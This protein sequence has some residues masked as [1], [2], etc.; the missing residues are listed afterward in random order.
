MVSAGA[1]GVA[2]CFAIMV[3]SN[4]ISQVNGFGGK[5]NKTL[6]DEYPTYLSPD[7][8][9]FAIWGFIY[10]F[11]IVLVGAQ[12]CP[13][14]TTER[15]LSRTC[16]LTGLDVRGRLMAAF[17]ANSLW[18]PVFNNEFFWAALLIILLYL[19][20]LLSTYIDLNVANVNSLTEAL[21]LTAGIALNTSWI[22]VASLV[23]AFLCFG[24]VGWKDEYGVAGSEVAA[25]LVVV[26][27]GVLG[28]ERALRG[29]DLAWAFV[30]SWA[31]R[32]IYR[33]QNFPD[34]ARFPLGAMS[35]NLALA[36]YA[37]HVVVAAVILLMAAYMLYRWY[38]R[39]DSWGNAESVPFGQTHCLE[40]RS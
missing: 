22:V 28:C 18:L 14:Q 6:S 20:F 35:Y 30:T 17:L 38:T 37:G 2:G 40:M 8:R 26:A 32:G 34:D 13:S 10:L 16:S 27:V 33:M 31:L 12:L 39:D 25:M 19:A 11:E 9:T 24:L 5:D 29:G 36:A 4:I 21:T 3:A 7:G 1:W 23:N 15:L